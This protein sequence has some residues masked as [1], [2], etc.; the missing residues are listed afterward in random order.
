MAHPEK[1][2]T[3][4]LRQHT[5]EK[6]KSLRAPVLILHSDQHDLHRLNKPLFLPIMQEAGVRVQY[7]EYPGYG[8][9]FYFGGGD[10]R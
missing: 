9:G 1:Y 4:E 6:L 2:F 5:R 7:R 8:H 3:V 10:D